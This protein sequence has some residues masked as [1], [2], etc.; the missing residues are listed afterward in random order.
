MARWRDGNGKALRDYPQPTVAVD[1]AVLTVPSPLA[2]DSQLHLLLHRRADGFATGNWALPATVLHK[3]ERLAKAA[4]RALK[5]KAGVSD[6]TPTQLQIFDDP[7]RDARGWVMS[8]AHVALVAYEPLAAAIAQS[9]ETTLVPVEEGLAKLPDRQR[10]LPFDQER[11]VELATQWAAQQYAATTDPFG[12]LAAPFT[13]TQLRQL[14]Q[15]VEGRLWQKDVFRRRVY[16][17]LQDVG[18]STVVTTGRPAK[19]LQRRVS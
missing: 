2:E 16:G 10:R 7:D 5:L 1:V 12:L 8:V 18:A 9:A 3:R 6:V 19:L 4:E 14:H 11:V 15:A 17:T 13:L